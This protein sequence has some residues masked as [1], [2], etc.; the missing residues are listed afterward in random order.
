MVNQTRVLKLFILLKSTILKIFS[1]NS[2]TIDQHFYKKLKYT[3]NIESHIEIF[4]ICQ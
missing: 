2:K 4:K 3:T 1:N